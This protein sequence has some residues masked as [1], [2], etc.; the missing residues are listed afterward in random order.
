MGCALFCEG[1]AFLGL[2]LGQHYACD[3]MNYDQYVGHAAY[4]TIGLEEWNKRA[5]RA[6]VAVHAADQQ[7]PHLYRRRKFAAHHV[8]IAGHGRQ[9][10]TAFRRCGGRRAALAVRKWIS[11]SLPGKT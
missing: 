5:E 8:R 2:E 10:R 9:R 6:I 7:R 4:L 11:G 3:D 1:S